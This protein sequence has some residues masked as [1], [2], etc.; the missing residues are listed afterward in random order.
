MNSDTLTHF[1]WT[2]LWQ[3]ENCDWFQFHLPLEYLTYIPEMLMYQNIKVASKTNFQLYYNNENI[4]S[5]NHGFYF[6]C[7]KFNLGS[8]CL[9][10]IVCSITISREGVGWIV[11]NYSSNSVWIQI[12]LIMWLRPEVWHP[13]IDWD[14]ALY[15]KLQ[16]IEQYWIALIQNL[17][18]WNTSKISMKLEHKIGH[19]NAKSTIGRTDSD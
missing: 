9:L 10:K 4:M 15:E 16:I 14:I 8:L 3:W 6:C 18:C 19:F 7:L 11:V 13:D 12:W 1:L 5:S 2:S 17:W